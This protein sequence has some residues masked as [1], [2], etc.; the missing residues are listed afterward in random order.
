MILYYAMG[1]GL[2]HLVRARAVVY[3]LGIERDTVLLSSS[4]GA[5]D[6]RVTGPLRTNQVSRPSARSGRL[7]TARANSAGSETERVELMRP[8]SLG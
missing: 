2:G 6:P 3:T 7:R 8:F 5:A 4:V 1:G